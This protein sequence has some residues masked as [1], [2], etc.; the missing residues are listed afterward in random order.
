[1]NRKEFL[2]KLN[3]VI[4]GLFFT[5]LN[6]QSANGAQMKNQKTK[7]W[8]WMHPWRRISD[9][10]Y[11]KRLEKIKLSGID[12][13]LPNV[14]GSWEA[15]YESQ[16]LSVHSP[17]LEK[18]LPIAKS[19]GLE[20]HAWMWTMICNNGEIIKEHPDWFAVNGNGESTIEKPAYVNYYRFMCPNHP[21]VQEFVTKTVSELATYSELDGVH[22]DYIRFPDVILAETLQKKYGIVQD[23]EYPEY[24]YCY[25]ERCK[26]K[27]KETT[28]I[29][30]NKEQQPSQNEAWRLF[31][32]DSITN[33][34]NNFLVPAA[35][36]AGKKI[37]AAVFPNWENVRQQ[38][39][40]W[41]VDAVLPMLYHSFYNEN[42]EWIQKNIINGIQSIDPSTKLYSG[43][44]I[45]SLKPNELN[46]AIRKSLEAGAHGVSLF[47]Y[48][49]MK[50][51]HWEAASKILK[52]C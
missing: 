36:K 7:N 33:L 50:E 13:I 26:S 27:F 37:S 8:L 3:A 19:V 11:K 48:H 46:E 22:L 35:Q 10:E 29:D 18:L 5:Q 44:F 31:R 12:A 21:G 14:Y 15:L 9:E 16:H 42:I 39:S 49:S 43:L 41:K 38:W 1:M 30:I 4:I 20:V 45:D 17:R 2:K 23:K 34:V 47:A 6:N 40:N 25:C 52:K 28:G 32:Y 51:A 24:D